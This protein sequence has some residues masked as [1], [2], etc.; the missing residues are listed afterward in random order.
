M[1]IQ[2]FFDSLAELPVFWPV[3]AVAAAFAAGSLI[4]WGRRSR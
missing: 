1:A 2:E 3:V 4:P